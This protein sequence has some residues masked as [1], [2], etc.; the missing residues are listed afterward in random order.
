MRRCGQTTR[1]GTP[2]RR[3]IDDD[4]VCACPDHEDQAQL[5]RTLCVD[6]GIQCNPF[7]APWGMR[8]TQQYMV[9]GDVWAAAGMR[10]GWL[11]VPCLEVR[12]GRHLSPADLTTAPIN[13]PWRYDDTDQLAS[14][15]LRA[16]LSRHKPL[17]LAV[18][19]PEDL[20]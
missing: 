14:L 10:H 19:H 18:G 3:I 2:C 17:W 20:L 15:K 9:H 16:A 6:C 5:G 7:D 8:D 13:D 4:I 12:L 11:C 1:K